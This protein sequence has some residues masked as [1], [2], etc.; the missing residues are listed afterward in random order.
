M[1]D[2][3][4]LAYVRSLGGVPEEILANPEYLE[5]MLP[6][7]RADLE[8]LE[9]YRYVPRAPLACPL[10]VAGATDDLE[11]PAASLEPWREHTTG[12][13]QLQMFA[14]GH[15]YLHEQRAAFTAFVK[16]ALAG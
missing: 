3:R 12:P 14:G 4:L 7:M 15:F 9:T 6:I 8:L 10:V 1:P 16:S 2:A 11:V 5:L 13:F